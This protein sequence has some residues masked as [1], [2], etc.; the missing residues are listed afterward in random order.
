MEYERRALSAAFHGKALRGLMQIDES[1][2]SFARDGL[3]G[4]FDC[5]VTVTAGRAKHVAHKAMRVH[6]NQ[7]WFAALFNLAADQG[8]MG[9]ASIHFTFVSDQP[10]FPMACGHQGLSD[11][12]DVAF[13][14]HA[15]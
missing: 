2:A 5:R 13:V 7:N 15:I 4:A 12:M 1:A 8:D 11:S 6:P 3:H 14:L 9:F 10:K